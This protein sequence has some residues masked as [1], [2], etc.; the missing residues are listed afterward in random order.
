MEE[1]FRTAVRARLDE[2]M[3]SL[4]SRTQAAADAAQ[5]DCAARGQQGAHD[6][7]VTDHVADS[8]GVPVCAVTRALS[9]SG[10]GAPLLRPSRAPSRP[11]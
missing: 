8:S 11:T 6:R 10:R 3:S 9:S 2:R 4:G 1:G 5:V 7:S